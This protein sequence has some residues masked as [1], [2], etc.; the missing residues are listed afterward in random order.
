MLEFEKRYAADQLRQ[1]QQQ[2]PAFQAHP[3]INRMALQ[4]REVLPHVPYNVVYKD[5][6]KYLFPCHFTGET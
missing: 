5:L 2:R 4:V 3:E 1:V 6:C